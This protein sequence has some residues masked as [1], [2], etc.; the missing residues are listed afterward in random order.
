MNEPLEDIREKLSR[1]GL[2]ATQQ[3]MVVYQALLQTMNQHPTAERIYEIVR[4]QNPSISLGTVYK[5][6]DIF[7]SNGLAGKV[8]SD[9]GYM[10]Y[11]V[12][13]EQHSHIYCTNTQEIIDYHDEAL[14]ELIQ[15]Y[16]QKK[17][18][19]NLRIGQIHVQISGQKENPEQEIEIID[20]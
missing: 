15:Q 2:K 10:R 3:R 9:A 1:A 4:P 14:D 12:N 17:N 16:F 18:I 5:T 8:A 13:V 11:D 6:L 19:K 20:L 7:V